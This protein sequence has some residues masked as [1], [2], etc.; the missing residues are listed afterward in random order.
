MNLPVAKLVTDL[1]SQ[2]GI[3]LRE[4]SDPGEDRRKKFWRRSCRGRSRRSPGRAACTGRAPQGCI[5]SGR[6]AGLWRCLAESRCGSRWAMPSAGNSSAGHRFL[7]KVEDSSAAAQ[8]ITFKSCR[9]ISC[10]SGPRIAGRRSK[11][12][13]AGW[14]AG[15][16]LRIHEDAH[17]MDL[18]TYLN[19]YP[20]GD[21]GRIRSGLSGTAGRNSDHGDARPSE[22]FRAGAQ[23]RVAGAQFPGGHQSR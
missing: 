12:N 1:D 16:G 4:A 18:V 6:F 19:E 3:S 23:G 22:I 17:L 13:C 7:G 5:L 11:R 14:P 21:P 2:G 15:R 8:R 10:W 9:P 20:D